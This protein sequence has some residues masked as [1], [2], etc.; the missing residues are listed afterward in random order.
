[1]HGELSL[2]QARTFLAAYRAGSLSR[3][4]RSLGL[5]QSAVTGQIAA[6]ERDLGYPLFERTASGVVPTARADSLAAAVATHLDG[7]ERSLW[8][9][10]PGLGGEARVLH[11]GGPAEYLSVRL[12]PALDRWRPSTVSVRVRFGLAESLLAELRTG[13]H[14][15]IISVVPVRGAEFETT[16]LYDEEFALVGSPDR[17]GRWL[18]GGATAP[19]PDLPVIAYAADLPIIRRW[20]RSVWGERPA[21][22]NVIATV[23]DLRT[24]TT[25]VVAGVGVSVLPTYLTEDHLADGSLVRLAEP[26]VPPLNTL[27][28]VTRAGAVA[29]DA[30]LARL[31]AALLDHARGR[32]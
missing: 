15:L 19:D 17:A 23:P 14:D 32:R 3:A 5:S 21:G 6:F 8:A 31:H 16:P 11:L 13:A 26:E 28:L 12:L 30:A 1:M 10:Q 9:A 24:I 22:L 29:R 27:S 4:A 7:L 20:W 25:M 2:D 18:A